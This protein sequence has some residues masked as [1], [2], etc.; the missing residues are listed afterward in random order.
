MELKYPYL[1]FL[2]PILIGFYLFIGKQK[3]DKK[4]VESKIA[5]TLFIKSTAYYK[6][7]LRNYNI[8]KIVVYTSFIIAII[9]AIILCSRPQKIET[10]N[11][12]DY[13]RDIFLCLDVSASV[14]QLNI[15][16]IENLKDTVRSLEGER[17]GIS[18]FNAYSVQVSPLTDDYEY[19][20]DSLDLIEASIK[21][22]NSL[23]FGMYQGKDY[24]YVRNYIYSGTICTQDQLDP[25]E[26][27]GDGSCRGSSL[28]GDGLASCIYSFPKLDQD[29][30]TRIIIFSTDNALEGTPLVT[31]EKAAEIAKKKNI[32]VYGIG[33]TV[34]VQQDRK[35]FK[36]AVE[37]TGGKFY[38]QA[39]YRVKSIVSDIEKT[40]KTLVETKYETKETDL[41]TIPFILLFISMVLIFI[42]RKKV[43]A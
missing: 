8:Y 29:D 17:F 42:F 33:T 34:M 2:L 4:K 9:C 40:S 12:N 36:S 24:N 28:I 14:D 37:I 15:E 13:K 39:S 11:I 18:M 23:I 25:V 21:A 10:N 3:K 35:D 1:L 6:K 16:L 31:L 5:N 32:K 30:R 38:D 26:Y 41:P 7:L 19:V 22:N 27:G 43:V 20:I